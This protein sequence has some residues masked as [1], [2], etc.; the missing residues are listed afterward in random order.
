MES[1]AVTVIDV[2][3]LTTMK[4]PPEAVLLEAKKAAQALHDVVA[5]K[6][7]PVIMN[8]E[9]YLEFEDWQTLGRFYGITARED[10]DAEFVDLGGVRGFKASAIAIDARGREISRATAYCLN[11]EEKWRGRPKYEYHYVLADDS[12]TAEDPGPDAIVWEPNP[13]KP[14]KSRP[15]KTRVLV[16]DEAVPLFQLS[17]MAQT[18]ANAK[19]LRNVLS[20]VVVLAGYRPT[21]A[22]EMD[23][24][25]ERQEPPAAPKATPQPPP[26]PAPTD[27][28]PGDD[29]EETPEEV[30]RRAGVEPPAR[31]AAPPAAAGK[32]P[33]PHCGKPAGQSKFPKANATHFCGVCKRSFAPVGG[34]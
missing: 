15:K 24:I 3:A 29:R 30:Y 10:G 11:D 20:W 28:D 34:K 33:C 4:D 21:P 5:Q 27:R 26:P 13:N 19:A 14:G 2:Q 32:V 12:T 17:S 7:R 25:Y 23:G 16:G 9:Q 18:R 1:E 22:E 31:K 8:G 6:A